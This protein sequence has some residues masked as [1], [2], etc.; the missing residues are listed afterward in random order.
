MAGS[1]GKRQPGRSRVTSGRELLEASVAD[2]A[3]FS[4]TLLTLP[5]RARNVPQLGTISTRPSLA[6]RRSALVTVL[7]ATPYC[8]ARS[9]TA[10][11]RSPGFHSPAAHRRRRS[12][13]TWR[14]GSSG[15]R[16]GMCTMIASRP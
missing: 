15:P 16:G 3:A 13:S 14:E 12:S 9:A 6:R 4:E 1:D 10:G 7:R 2:V 8:W 11:S 5:L